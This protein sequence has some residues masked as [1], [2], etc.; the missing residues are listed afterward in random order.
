MMGN[1]QQQNAQGP[2]APSLA[3]TITHDHLDKMID[4]MTEEEKKDMLGNLPEGQ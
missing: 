2:A 1:F 3:A 4:E